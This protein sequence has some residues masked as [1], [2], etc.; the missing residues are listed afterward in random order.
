MDFPVYR[1]CRPTVSPR[2]RLKGEFQPRPR[3]AYYSE[4]HEESR[5]SPIHTT[6]FSKVLLEGEQAGEREYAGIEPVWGFPRPIVG[7]H[8]LL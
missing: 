2:P 5:N 6:N 3:G 1:G 4:T 8:F 7:R